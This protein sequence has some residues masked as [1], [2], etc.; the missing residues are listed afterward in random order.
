MSP[1]R[2]VDRPGADPEDQNRLLVEVGGSQRPFMRGIMVHS[3]MARG[4]SF[5]EAYRTAENVRE[6]VRGR[7]VVPSGE[8]AKL[9]ED[10][11]GPD[12]LSDPPPPTSL[13]AAIQVTSHGRSTPFSKGT[14]SQSV[15]AASLD[16]TD[17][18]D[19]A[20]EIELGLVKRR[21]REI[22][23]TDLRR[24][25][26]QTLLQRFG[27]QTAQRFLVW[28]SYQEPEKPVIILL[29]GTTGAG[30]TSL[31]LEVAR[32]LGIRRVLSSDSIRQIMRIML[33]PE[34]IP[35]LHVSSFD[36]H[37]HVPVSAPG[38]DPEL[39]GFLAQASLVSVGV[40]GILD[41]AVAENTSLVLDGVTLLP[42]LIDLEAYADS[43]HVIFLVVAT[44]DEEAFAGRFESRGDRQRQ[45]GTHRYL[46]NLAGILKIQNYFLE[47]ADR[48]DVPIVDNVSIDSSVMLIIRHVVDTLRKKGDADV[49]ALR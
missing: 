35:A 16:P 9:V 34:L 10:L 26:H 12:A 13:P 3:L 47:L 30:K 45:R 33:S 6:R 28:R 22:S 36:A 41:R 27:E 1:P 32:R 39:E 15:L 38:E 17:A 5:E 49:D 18:F 23:R 43:A 25:A 19:V 42:G 7:G 14:L 2:E 4:V 8:L 31:A 29:G 37:R 40:R 21:N 11:L 44:L 20:R 46:E 48:Y 24:L